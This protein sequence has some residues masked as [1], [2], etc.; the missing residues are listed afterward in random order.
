M[1]EER[2][3]CLVIQQPS[4]CKEAKRGSKRSHSKS[5]VAKSSKPEDEEDCGTQAV[6]CSLTIM[7]INPSKKRDYTMVKDDKSVAEIIEK[8]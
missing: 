6:K 3:H 4:H 5:P 2:G 1:R 7:I 8:M